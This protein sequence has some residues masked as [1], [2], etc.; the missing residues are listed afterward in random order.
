MSNGH[1]KIISVVAGTFLS[2]F[3]ISFATW[4][5]YV[6]RRGTPKN[7]L[8]ATDANQPIPLVTNM[9]FSDQGYT[10]SETRLY[11]PKSSKFTYTFWLTLLP[12]VDVGNHVL[13]V[14]G[15]PDSY[16]MSCASLDNPFSYRVAMP[17]VEANVDSLGQLTMQVS[18]NTTTHKYLQIKLSS[19]NASDMVSFAQGQW[20]HFTISFEDELEGIRMTAYAN[21]TALVSLDPQNYTAFS[22]NHLM[23]NDGKVYLFP[24]TATKTSATNTDKQSTKRIA[25]GRLTY[26]PYTLTPRQITSLSKQNPPKSENDDIV[27][28]IG[29]STKPVVGAVN[30]GIQTTPAIPSVNSSFTGPELVLMSSTFAPK[31][32]TSSST[33]RECAVPTTDIIDSVGQLG[34]D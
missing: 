29:K 21:D 13:F 14:N 18:I 30:T 34:S 27:K 23:H 5:A 32:Q 1:T 22:G 15:T 9:R 8:V 2:L 10:S 12:D 3:L 7:Y 16:T 28:D 4:L 24:N 19:S 26:H 17:C 6:Q 11:V 20:I 31:Q 33:T 25:L